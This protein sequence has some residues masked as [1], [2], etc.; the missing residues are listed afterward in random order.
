MNAR[1]DQPG[2]LI[3][4]AQKCGTSWLH[5]QLSAHP[6]LW[7]PANKELEFFSYLAHLDSPGLSHYRQA[8]EAAD[9]RLA[10]EATASYLW[11]GSDSPWCQQPDGFNPDIPGTVAASLGTA[12]RLIACVRD[13]VERALSAWAHYVLHGELDPALPLRDAAHYGGIVDMGFYRRHLDRWR[14]CFP[15]NQLLVLSLER[16]IADAPEIALSRCF[17]HLGVEDVSSN[18]ETLRT[19][20]FPGLQ[21][22]RTKHGD[23]MISLPDQ[24][25]ALRAS[26]EDLAWLDE[27]FEADRCWMAET[28]GARPDAGASRD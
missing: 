9:G 26:A 12:I 18:S 22:Q 10:G 27:L 19:V 28:F 8:F 17:R 6:E 7:L 21:R 20:V 23:V 13:P 2:F 5:R 24:Q 11:T 14:A 16:D 15:E 25:G 4:G 3:I 1:E